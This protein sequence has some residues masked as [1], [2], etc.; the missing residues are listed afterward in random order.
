MVKESTRQ[1]RRCR[2]SPWVGKIPWRRKW[3]P[4]LVFLPEQSHG[5]RSLAGYSPWDLREMDTTTTEQQQHIVDLVTYLLILLILSF[6]EQKIFCFNKVEFILCFIDLVVNV[7]YKKSSSYPTSSRFFLI[8]FLG[9]L[10]L[11]FTF[12]PAIY[13]ELIL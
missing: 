11:Y 6:T 3:Q 5:Q 1:C 8:C 9:V 4:T 13:L 10:N 2:F 12:K 7:L